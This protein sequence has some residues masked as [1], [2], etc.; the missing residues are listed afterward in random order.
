ML[1]SAC[2]YAIR[3]VLHLAIT[4]SDKKLSGKEIAEALDVPPPFL[5]KLLQELSKKNLISSSKG[6]RGGFYLT[7]DNRSAPLINVV[8]QIDGLAWFEQ[9]TLGLPECGNVNPCP[10]HNAIQPFKIEFHRTLQENS[11][12]DYAKKIKNGESFLHF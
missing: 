5:A 7:E 2:K 9:C 3:A 10:I 12:D 8:N 1:S 11:V 6:P 4:A